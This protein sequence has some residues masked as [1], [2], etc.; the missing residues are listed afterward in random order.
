MAPYEQYR[1]LIVARK[2]KSLASQQHPYFR[3]VYLNLPLIMPE[4]LQ[5]TLFQLR[6]RLLNV[7][8]V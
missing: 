2:I 3:I 8:R 1:V 4:S 7:M 5:D 6:V